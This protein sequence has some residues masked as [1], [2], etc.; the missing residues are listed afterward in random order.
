MENSML[1]V[2][3]RWDRAR[4]CLMGDMSSHWG[5]KRQ[6]GMPGAQVCRIE[7]LDGHTGVYSW[8]RKEPRGFMG[9]VMS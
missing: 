7:C 5:M 6:T 3:W 9:R 2:E 4:S 8:D 1:K